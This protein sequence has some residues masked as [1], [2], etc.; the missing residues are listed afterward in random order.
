ME[1]IKIILICK[2]SELSA[3][4]AITMMWCGFI[5]RCLD[6]LAG[7]NCFRHAQ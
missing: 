3:F 7:L 6:K 2:H 5:R 4:Q 1:N